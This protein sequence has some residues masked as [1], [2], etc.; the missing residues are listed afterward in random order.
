MT[1]TTKASKADQHS[2]RHHQATN[3]SHRPQTHANRNRT[4]AESGQGDD[5]P[6]HCKTSALRQNQSESRDKFRLI[7]FLTWNTNQQKSIF[8]SKFLKLFN[9]S[10][11]SWKAWNKRSARMTGT[12]LSCWMPWPK[13]VFDYTT[14]PRPI[15]D[16]DSQISNSIKMRPCVIKAGFHWSI[17][18]KFHC[19]TE[20]TF[21]AK[22][23]IRTSRTQDP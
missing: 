8:L 18:A 22:A 21:Q 11:R 1:I 6:W 12:F 3:S 4:I 14:R 9:P 16:F 20:S 2:W 13:N 19:D 15:S 23:S 17:K 5:G 10:T 7:I